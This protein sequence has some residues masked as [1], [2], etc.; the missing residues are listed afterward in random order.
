MRTREEMAAN[1][2]VPLGQSNAAA[3]D[4]H[5]S[6]ANHHAAAIPTEL[7]AIQ[8]VSQDQVTRADSGGAPPAPIRRKAVRRV[9]IKLS[10]TSGVPGADV[11]VGHRATDNQSPTANS[12]SGQLTRESQDSSA[13]PD[14]SAGHHIGVPLLP[15]ASVGVDQVVPD[16]HQVPVHPLTFRPGTFT[17]AM[18]AAMDGVTMAAIQ[19]LHREH[20]AIQR[21][22]GDMDRR[23]KAEARW[24]A[25]RRYRAEG[26][27]LPAGKFPDVTKADEQMVVATRVRFFTIR[28]SIEA[29]RKACQKELLALVKPLPIMA[30]AKDVKGLGIASVAAIIG[31][32]GDLANYANP[33]K[34]WKRMG[35]AV[36]DGKSQGK[37]T[38]AEEAARHGYSP[39]RRSEMHVVGDCMVRAGGPYADLY[40]ARKAVEMER[41]GITKMHAH[42]RALRYIEK[43]LL[44]EM[45]QVWR[46]ATFAVAPNPPLPSAEELAGQVLNDTRD[47]VAGQD[48]DLKHRDFQL[49]HV[50]VQPS[51]AKR[52]RRARSGTKPNGGMP[53]AEMAAAE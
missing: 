9:K 34:L 18:I 33:G 24:F 6:C 32:A 10:P 48:G 4:G 47:T 41:D 35:L 14:Q 28:A 38:N 45:W 13:A 27:P 26:I 25:V 7:S 8:C 21:A 3:G 20:R 53:G 22:V 49:P 23:I 40:R 29:E 51:R 50:S 52:V 12:G 11:S 36:I 46:G 19:S 2:S 43:R 30:W 17:P 42:K 16:I 15:C 31:E 5:V 37:R 39:Q 1:G 44:R